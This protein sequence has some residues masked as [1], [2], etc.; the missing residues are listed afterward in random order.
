MEYQVKKNLVGKLMVYY[1][2]PNCREPLSSGLVQAGQREDCPSCHKPFLVPGTKEL[3]QLQQ[4]RDE[5]KRTAQSAS[6]FPAP[7][8][9]S[10]SGAEKSG[11]WTE[12][13]PPVP[14][15]ASPAVSTPENTP[16]AAAWSN[17]YGAPQQSAESVSLGAPHSTP[18]V[19]G[20][21]DDRYY[22][23]K[24]Y[25]MIMRIIGAVFIAL[26]AVLF[27]LAVYNLVLQLQG[28]SF[29]ETTPYILFQLINITSVTLVG[30][31]TLGFGELL[32]CIRDMA[33]NSFKSLAQ[34]SRL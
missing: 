18:R 32:A 15:R 25:C 22:F 29:R 11:K 28:N 26:A 4:R 1:D 9:S 23:L 33:I 27:C 5:K 16:A 3:E 13:P 8:A 14:A 17:P 31:F 24:I 19:I 2:C 20:R 21:I 10:G 7:P 30:L 34:N 12:A 6:G